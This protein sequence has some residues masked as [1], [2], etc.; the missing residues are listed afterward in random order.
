[1]IL[2]ATDIEYLSMFIVCNTTVR[3][4]G[5]RNAG[6]TVKINLQSLFCSNLQNACNIKLHLQRSTTIDV[7]ACGSRYCQCCKKCMRK[8][9]DKIRTGSK[10]CTSH[11]LSELCSPVPHCKK[12]GRIQCHAFFVCIFSLLLLTLKRV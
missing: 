2:S 11:Q 10:Y 5:P 12:L 3:I 9:A 7:T 4:P 1:M 8:N 6:E